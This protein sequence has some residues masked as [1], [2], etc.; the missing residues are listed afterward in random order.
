M[1]ISQSKIYFVN[2]LFL[3][4]GDARKHIEDKK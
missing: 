3:D 1:V 4:V 2:L